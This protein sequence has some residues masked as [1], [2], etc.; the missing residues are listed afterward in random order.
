MSVSEEVP[1]R[2]RYRLGLWLLPAAL[3]L[4]VLLILLVLSDGGVLSA[5]G[6]RSF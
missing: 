4:L 1:R 6:Y 5:L 3:V 2:R